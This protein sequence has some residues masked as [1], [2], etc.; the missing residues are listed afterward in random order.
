MPEDPIALL[1]EWF[2]YWSNNDYMPAKMP[3]SLHTRTIV[4]LVEAKWSRETAE[5]VSADTNQNLHQQ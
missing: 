4:C 3:N 5:V 1:Q 2:D